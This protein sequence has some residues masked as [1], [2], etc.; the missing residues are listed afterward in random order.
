VG[1]VFESREKRLPSTTIMNVLV[2]LLPRSV[3]VVL[4]I[5]GASLEVTQILHVQWWRMNLMRMKTWS[6]SCFKQMTLRNLI[7]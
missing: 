7:M 4:S 2:A 5:A 1:G 6:P 3:S